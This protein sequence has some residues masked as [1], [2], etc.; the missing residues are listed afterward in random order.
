M[1][2]NVFAE[3]AEKKKRERM[4]KEQKERE[5]RKRKYEEKKREEGALHNAFA[6]RMDK[7]RREYEEKK[8][9][10]EAKNRAMNLFKAKLAALAAKYKVYLY[11]ISKHNSYGNSNIELV[12]KIVHKR[13][14]RLIDYFSTSG[15]SYPDN[16]FLSYPDS[17]IDLSI[18][19]YDLLDDRNK[20]LYHLIVE[21]INNI[22]EDLKFTYYL[23]PEDEKLIPYTST[24]K[25]GGGAA[26]IGP[27]IALLERTSDIGALVKVR[28]AALD[29]LYDRLRQLDIIRN[30]ERLIPEPKIERV[31][32]PVDS[33]K[34][35]KWVIKYLNSREYGRGY[36]YIVVPSITCSKKEP[37]PLELWEPKTYKIGK[38]ADFLNHNLMLDSF[39][40]TLGHL[41]PNLIASVRNMVRDRDPNS[42]PEIEWIVLFNKIFFDETNS[43]TN[44]DR[45]AFYE[46]VY[47]FVI[48]IMSG[49]NTDSYTNQCKLLTSILTSKY[50]KFNLYNDALKLKSISCLGLLSWGLQNLDPERDEFLA[51]IKRKI[52]RYL[53]TTNIPEEEIYLEI[54]EDGI[55]LEEE[56]M[57]LRS[58]Y[59]DDEDIAVSVK[60]HVIPGPDMQTY[61][62]KELRYD[63]RYKKRNIVSYHK[64][65]GD[66]IYEIDVSKY[67]ANRWID[68]SNSGNLCAITSLIY[69]PIVLNRI[70]KLGLSLDHFIGEIIL[71]SKLYHN[72]SLYRVSKSKLREIHG[73][74]MN[75]LG[76][77]DCVIVYKN[78]YTRSHNNTLEYVGDKEWTRL[79]RKGSN[80]KNK[81]GSYVWDRDYEV[82]EIIVTD[83]AGQVVLDPKYA[84]YEDESTYTYTRLVRPINVK[85]DR[86]G[87]VITGKDGS[88]TLDPQYATY[89]DRKTYTAPIRPI[90]AK[91]DVEVII[92]PKVLSKDR[93][94][95]LKRIA[96]D[97]SKRIDI[98]LAE[99]HAFTVCDNRHRLHLLKELKK[100]RVVA[101]NPKYNIIELIKI[102]NLVS[103][104]LE[105][106]PALHDMIGSE[107]NRLEVGRKM[108]CESKEDYLYGAMKSYY[109]SMLKDTLFEEQLEVVMNKLNILYDIKLE[110]AAKP[111]NEMLKADITETIKELVKINPIFGAMEDK[112]TKVLSSMCG[113]DSVLESRQYYVGFDYE[114]YTDG[115]ALPY[116][117]TYRFF[118]DIN[119]N[120]VKPIDGEIKIT[121]ELLEDKLQEGGTIHN[122]DNDRTADE[123]S[124][125]MLASMVDNI[126]RQR[127]F[128]YSEHDQ[129][130]KL[131][132]F[133]HN[134][135]RF[136]S[137]ILVDALTRCGGKI[138]K[139]DV[140]I[141]NEIRPGRL[142]Y[143]SFDLSYEEDVPEK[144]EYDEQ[145]NIV[146]DDEPERDEDGNI[147][148]EECAPSTRRVIYHFSCVDSLLLLECRVDQIA[149]NF[150]VEGAVKGNYPYQLYGYVIKNK[151]PLIYTKQE[152][153]ELA[154]GTNS[155][156][157][158][159]IEEFM[160]KDDKEVYDLIEMFETYCMQDTDIMCKG[161]IKAD[162]MY[163]S[164]AM[165]E[166]KAY[167]YKGGANILNKS[168]YII[169]L[170][171]AT[172]NKCR[173]LDSVTL[174]SF[175][176]AIT[177]YYV[178]SQSNISYTGIDH[179]YLSVYTGGL[180][181]SKA[182]SNYV[183][184][185]M[186]DIVNNPYFYIDPIKDNKSVID[187]LASNHGYDVNKPKL[188]YDRMNPPVEVE[189]LKEKM[190]THTRS[191]LLLL[192]ANSLYPSA[193]RM[194]ADF[195]GFPINE[196][197][198]FKASDKA[199]VKE[200]LSNDTIRW[201]GYVRVKW[202]EEGR[203][204][205]LSP[206][207]LMHPIIIRTKYGNRHLRA[208]DKECMACPMD[209]MIYKSVRDHTSNL[210]TLEIINGVYW[211]KTSTTFSY[212][213]ERV[214]AER[215]K[216]K[217]MKSPI[218]SSVKKLLNSFYG[219]NLEK[220]HPDKVVFKLNNNGK[221]EGDE[222]V[223]SDSEAFQ[224][225]MGNMCD[226]VS[227]G[228]YDRI[229]YIDME[230]LDNYYGAVQNG[231]YVL[232]ASKY[233]MNTL[234]SK[235]DWDI[236]YTDTDS[237]FIGNEQFNRIKNETV[238]VGDKI[239]SLMGPDLGQFKPDFDDKMIDSMAE[240]YPKKYDADGEEIKNRANVA[241]LVPEYGVVSIMS[242]F[243]A[244]KQYCN[245]LFGQVG[246]DR[247]THLTV[248]LQTAG[249][250]VDHKALSLNDYLDVN[251]GI[252]IEQDR[253]L[254]KDTFIVKDYKVTIHAKGTKANKRTIR[255][256]DVIA[257]DRK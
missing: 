247:E 243:N 187:H 233:K 102:K 11:S 42:I 15:I 173:F 185:I 211:P 22:I 147:I 77:T 251:Q 145:G 142:K 202:T 192:D 203:K 139:Y 111:W 32:I 29:M 131:R 105:Y 79:K 184:S 257:K 125:T 189:N 162:T 155:N 12:N 222:I 226:V 132:L 186:D 44:P 178:I 73:Y 190:R 213:C 146:E 151:L 34:L 240:Y 231:V 159:S 123:I 27:T 256:Q 115:D 104:Y 107:L 130:Y 255:N 60:A 196:Y 163:H 100:Q 114:T 217:K 38:G 133:S 164:I 74:I 24:R 48:G 236:I 170:D 70:V 120:Y 124:Y 98:I 84:T 136:D 56:I 209:D 76:L 177:R 195:G 204:K 53:I 93:D 127:K 119:L 244:K 254:T 26:V 241:G 144:P 52:L 110:S 94:L 245:L 225:K 161:L 143:V 223:L 174:S 82:R 229:S 180:T 122:L 121:N 19:D 63:T 172:V 90:N 221:R 207:G 215:L 91:R 116:G 3:I 65:F 166:P 235:L 69:N 228:T 188:T 138:G 224:E 16:P 134:G 66:Y 171:Y 214:Y 194:M 165:A 46:K 193:I 242:I 108:Y 10:E 135:G 232:G 71:V 59:T 33:K 9:A 206:E 150:K 23:R 176:K 140:A 198:K 246:D 57:Q 2:R 208:D 169:D 126:E 219:V 43:K 31:V 30:S 86:D 157:K 205:S 179:E 14:E 154:A 37:K 89:D 75:K 95:E 64:Y 210:Y 18:K 234:F 156:I 167:V 197:I 99:G 129:H 5:E 237:A 92:K 50:G 17:D 67:E 88:V 96:K 51:G 191:C 168:G 49:T 97:K 128:S 118:E 158:S 201:L 25:I 20:E 13:G 253:N 35:F 238:K 250:G 80:I 72:D 45:M 220:P 239:M 62:T 149:K 117:V 141:N 78:S 230:S 148:Y 106:K 55:D 83:K 54:H 152:L 153:L 182:V 40:I 4:E 61:L 103:E 41:L 21:E 101:V 87:N 47:T 39:N 112:V 137:H 181:Y 160:K 36:S 7:A 252:N 28:K 248:K 218:E 8:R 58:N 199:T 109:R 200:L 249:K 68:N 216:Y 227:Y 113:I 1:Q 175:S 85:R 81:D 212:L 183:S 6:E